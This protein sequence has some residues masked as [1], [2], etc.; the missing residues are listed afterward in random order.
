MSQTETSQNIGSGTFAQTDNIFYMQKVQY[1]H[2]IL[3]EGLQRWKL[4][5]IFAFQYDGKRCRRKKF[6]WKKK[7]DRKREI[8]QLSVAN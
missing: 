5:A 6:E 4:K 2:Q 7:K 1:G 8:N 3:A